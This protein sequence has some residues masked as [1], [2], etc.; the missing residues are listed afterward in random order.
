MKLKK[1]TPFIQQTAKLMSVVV[2]SLCFGCEGPP[3]QNTVSGKSIVN[4]SSFAITA[5]D[6]NEEYVMVTTATSLPL[7]ATRDQVA[8]RAWGKYRGV[9]VSVVGPSDW[10]IPAQIKA[11]EEVISSRPAGMLINGTDPGIAAAINKAVEA[12]IPT[13]VYDSEVESKRHCF[14]GSDWY[15]MG[16][17]QG[18]AVGRLANGKKGKVAAVGI[19]NLSNQQA[20]FDGLEAAL[21]RF[22]N[23]EY[24]G[25]F[26]THNTIE[27]T[28]R[29]TTDLINTY[30]DLVAV[31]GFSSETGPGIG[32]GLKEMNVAGKV[33]GTN[34][35]ASLVLLNLLKE[36]V[37][38]YLV[39]QK[40]ETFV[41]Y[42]AE[43]VFD[44]AHN[45]HAF[46]PKYLST[47][48]HGLPYS[49]NTGLIEITPE[50]VDAY[51]E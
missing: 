40:R 47:G 16:Y 6:P 45:I 7:Y 51:L 19:L 2:L 46:S 8:F 32:L 18:E 3:R 25:E 28:A 27:E 48:V 30:K 23:L 5:V 26:D 31:C 35:D 36:N 20:G 41:W 22:P 37:L 14:L 24:I 4:D 11:I 15:Q 43:F 38:Q 17:K 21:K 1:I 33:F 44:M 34:V 42:G 49:V 9:K 50:T 13:I 29:I 39:D 12:G 10:N